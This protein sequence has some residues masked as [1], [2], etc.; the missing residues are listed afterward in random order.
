VARE[1]PLTGS[2]IGRFPGRGYTLGDEDRISYAERSLDADID[3]PPGS[4]PGYTPMPGSYGTN[5]PPFEGAGAVLMT[6]ITDGI[7]SESSISSADSSDSAPSETS[8]TRRRQS[9]LLPPGGAERPVSEQAV[10]RGENAS[11]REVIEACLLMTIQTVLLVEA[12]PCL[13]QTEEP[14]K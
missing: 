3:T 8:N 7:S 5:G 9:I 14:P 6:G 10:G 12:K 11:L 4:P 13:P 2:D 1:L